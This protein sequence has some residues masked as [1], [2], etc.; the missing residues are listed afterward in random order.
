M[1][2]TVRTTRNYGWVN[3]HVSGPFSVDFIWNLILAQVIIESYSHRPC[4]DYCFI[5]LVC[6]PILKRT[7]HFGNRFCFRPQMTGWETPTPLGSLERLTS[8]TEQEL[9]QF[10]GPTSDSNGPI[11]VGN[12]GNGCSSL[13]VVFLEHRTTG[14]SKTP[15]I[16]SVTQHRQNPLESS[17]RLHTSCDLWIVT[18]SFQTSAAVKHADSSRKIRMR[19]AASSAPVALKRRAANSSSEY[20]FS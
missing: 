8:L 11:R 14:K 9:A 19:L 20:K 17:D 3:L 10:S 12:D 16:L 15:A 1:C 6:R 18:T 7:Q 2:F 5:N 4:E 13:N